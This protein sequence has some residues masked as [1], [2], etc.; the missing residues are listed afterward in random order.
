MKVY[1]IMQFSQQQ[2]CNETAFKGHFPIDG[3]GGAKLVPEWYLADAVKKTAEGT[4]LFGWVVAG[5]A[6]VVGLGSLLA[7][8]IDKNLVNTG[9]LDTSDIYNPEMDRMYM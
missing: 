7:H 3:G 4:S 8:E 6:A 1:P 2:K 5:F 9:E